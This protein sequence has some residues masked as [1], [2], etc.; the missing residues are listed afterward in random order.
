MATKV[1]HVK[2]ARDVAAA[3]K[4]GARALRA[5]KL[6]AFP[7]E[8]VYGIAA[9]AK[10]EEAL[11]RLREL[12][13][14]PKRPFSV[15]LARPQDAKRYVREMPAAARQIIAKA[16]PG[17]V[18]LLLATGGR[19]ADARLQRAGLYERLCADGVIGLR[20]PDDPV[21]GA[22]LAAVGGPVVA[23]SANLAG[24]RPPRSGPEV[25]DSLDGRIDL[26]ID[27]GPTR[28]GTN[29]TILRF[30]GD[31]WRIARKGV[32]DAR[33]IRRFAR[34]TLLFVCTGNTC[35][36]PIAMGLAKQL[37]AHRLS[38]AVGELRGKG[39]EIVSA[40]VCAFDG[41]RPTPEAVGAARR[42][43]ADIARHRSRKL[44]IE[45]INRADVIFCMT[46]GHVASVGRLVPSAADK[47][48]R[49]S[50]RAGIADPI[51][52]GEDVYHD[53]AREILCALHVL[54]DK[55]MP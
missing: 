54:W 6:V 55:R 37:A 29:S 34:R 2:T 1:I 35:R 41:G 44:T 17:P 49:L 45:L 25:L 50:K 30:S 16:W 18:T 23:P 27:R 38:C 14:R 20:C 40:G 48:Q 42:L 11:A 43:G 12:K 39:V 28:Y 46:D 21:A 8:T 32:Y 47:V 10:N 31:N 7:T 5:G 13:D 15:H 33:A 52:G 19:L 9:E 24:R 53:T 4:A 36:S 26:L 22:M 3:A 51:G